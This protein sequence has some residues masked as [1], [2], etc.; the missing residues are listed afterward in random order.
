MTSE[1]KQGD[2]FEKIS[3]C[4]YHAIIKCAYSSSSNFKIPPQFS[5]YLKGARQEYTKAL[6]LLRLLK[7]SNTEKNL[8]EPYYMSTRYSRSKTMLLD[9]DE[10]LIHSEE[11]D[12]AKA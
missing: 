4:T 6:R 5:E 2:H 3:S 10:T 7:D 1:V 9:M 8:P 11:L 12:P